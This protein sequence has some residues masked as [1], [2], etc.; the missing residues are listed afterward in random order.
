MNVTD[1]GLHL[2]EFFM[3]NAGK[4]SFIEDFAKF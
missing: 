4:I 2:A 3:G 1:I